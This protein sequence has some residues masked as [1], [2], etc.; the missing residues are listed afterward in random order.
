MVNASIASQE[1]SVAA[2]RCSPSSANIQRFGSS[3]V[4]GGMTSLDDA[5]VDLA[6]DLTA[7]WFVDYN[8]EHADHETGLP[9][10]TLRI[11]SFLVHRGER[12][13]SRSLLGPTLEY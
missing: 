1:V 8:E 11:P 13:D 12:I 7:T 9:V 5:Q 2:R 6:P 10:G 4:L 3:V